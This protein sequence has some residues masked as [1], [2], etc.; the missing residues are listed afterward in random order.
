VE[1]AFSYFKHQRLE[2]THKY[3]CSDVILLPKSVY[4]LMDE[5]KYVELSA[6]KHFGLPTGNTA[7]GS[8]GG[9]P[10]TQFRTISKS[11]LKG[12]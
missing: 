5:P 2:L 8:G 6:V 1:H 11:V 12:Q 7:G 4:Q 9:P 10:N 3:E